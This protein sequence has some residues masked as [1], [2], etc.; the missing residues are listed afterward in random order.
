[1]TT[2]ARLAA[3]ISAGLLNFAL[4]FGPARAGGG[5]IPV[6][7]QYQTSHVYVSQ[8]DVDLFVASL[9]ATFGGSKKPRRFVQ[10]TPMPSEAISQL[11]QTPVGTF[12]VLGFRTPIPY[13]FGVERY[14]YMVND[15]EAALAVA[16]NHGADIV[17]AAFPDAFG[18]DAIIEWPGGLH[19]QLYAHKQKLTY[20]ALETIPEE[21]VYVSPERTEAFVTAFKEFA[22]A[23]VVSDDRAAPGV[24]IGRPNDSYRRIRL[25]S[26]FGKLT[27]LVTDGQLPYP[28]G[29]EDAGYEVAD[30]AETISK[31]EAAGVRV[32]VKPYIASGR[33]AAILQ[34]PGGYIAEIH[35]AASGNK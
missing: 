3:L 26:E 27:V 20:P 22:D 8:S 7:P 11:V 33:V 4:V 6:G 16:K 34:F 9:I 15:L 30:I 12:S 35:A 17:V 24:E 21:H 32:L 10:I 13:P 2:L 1:M 28:Y 29:R 23:K 14:G 25:E 31:A 19:V 18:N 5:P